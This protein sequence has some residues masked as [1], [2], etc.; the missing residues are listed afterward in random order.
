MQLCSG[1]KFLFLCHWKDV[2]ALISNF[3]HMRQWSYRLWNNELN[4]MITGS[5]PVV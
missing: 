1:T 3:V 5:D 4:Y 2:T